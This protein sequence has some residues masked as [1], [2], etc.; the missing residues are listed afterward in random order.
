VN[1]LVTGGAGYIGSVLVGHLLAN[2]YHVTVLDSLMYG[3]ESLL[4]YH[5]HPGFHLIVG[6]VRVDS[7]VAHALESRPTVVVHLAAIVGEKACKK[8]DRDTVVSVNLDATLKL[9]KRCKREEIPHFIFASTCSNYGV[10]DGMLA[11]DA[12]LKPLSLYAETKVMAE[13]AVLNHNSDGFATT[14]LRFATAYGLSPRTRLDV[15]LNEFAY[16]AVTTG[17]LCVYNKSAWRPL[18]HV[19]DI[20]EA[21]R[22]CIE[23][24][25]LFAGEVINVGGHNVTKD[26]LVF[27]LKA[28]LPKLKVTYTE[29]GRDARDYR[30][31][32]GKL[33]AMGYRPHYVPTEGLREIVDA[34]QKGIIR[35]PHCRRWRNA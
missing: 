7:D 32:F 31:N 28:L 5:Y 18:A 30:V 15:M 19:R 23:R 20:A 27:A 22:F 1:I 14:A 21:V 8:L 10:A 29:T 13:S 12:E 16:D 25:L 35:D 33:L 3:G 24:R 6:D 4:A 26:D 11:E 2:G 17:K 34:L 9:V